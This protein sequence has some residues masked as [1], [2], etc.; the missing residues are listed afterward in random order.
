[1]GKYEQAKSHYRQ[2]LAIKIEYGD[3]HSQATTYN[4]SRCKLSVDERG[5][6]SSRKDYANLS[7]YYRKLRLAMTKIEIIIKDEQGEELTRLQSIDLELGS[8]SLDEI[9]TAVEKLKQKIIPEISSE[10]LSQAQ[11][12]FTNK[13]LF[14]NLWHGKTNEVLTY[15]KTQITARNQQKLDELITYITKHESEIINYE[16]RRQIGKNI[17]SGRM[18]KGVDLVIGNRQKHKGMSWSA[19]LM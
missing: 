3:R 8:Q 2:A 10:L 15:L 17:G 19:R 13:F 4:N 12:E 6:F 14:F 11:R 9:E 5:R 7:P 18:E 1:M 16:L